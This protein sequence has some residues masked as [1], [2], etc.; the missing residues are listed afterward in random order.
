MI[1]KKS[2]EEMYGKLELETNTDE[3]TEFVIKIGKVG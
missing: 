1:C 2:I 3:K